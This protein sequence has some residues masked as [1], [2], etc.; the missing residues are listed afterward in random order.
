MVINKNTQTKNSVLL[1]TLL[2]N[3]TLIFLLFLF[4]SQTRHVDGDEGLYLEAARLVAQ[5]KALYFDFFYQQMP[6]LPYL[7]AGWMKV[8]G[9]DFF[10]GRWFSALLTALTGGIFL[11]YVARKT[12]NLLLINLFALLFFSN[13]LI[14]AWAPVVK[15][16][17]LSLLGLTSSCVF[18][19]IWRE[20]QSWWLIAL[21]ALGIGVGV[22]SRLTLGPFILIYLV[23][24]FFKSDGHKWRD[25][26]LFTL[27]VALVSLPS[28]YYFFSDP[29]LFW[30]YNMLYHTHVYPG[31]VD[32]ERRLA[33]AQNLFLGLQIVL[34]FLA[35]QGSILLLI[36]KGWRK[37][38][39][40]DEAFLSLLLL[41][42]IGIHM[43][44][45][46]PYTQYFVTMIPLLLMMSVPAI[47]EIW[48]QPKILSIP[49][50]TVFVILYLGNAKRTMNYE[51]ASMLSDRPEWSLQNIQNTVKILKTTVK[52]GES[53]L[54][55]WPGYAF[56]AGCSSV[57]G[58][59]N[60]MRN[61]GV[62][63]LTQQE[64]TD[65][66]MLSDEDLYGIIKEGKYRVMV[67]GLYH[68][69]SPL[70]KYISHQIEHHYISAGGGVKVQYKDGSELF[71]LVYSEAFEGSIR[72]GK[73]KRTPR[74]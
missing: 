62:Q 65:Y 68:I 6:L 20:K 51:I 34:L 57:P 52:P 69:Q 50:I 1:L 33:T 31:V 19:L 35:A 18:L 71:D 63:K 73:R 70:Y 11:I 67:D 53:C 23:Y 72:N 15:T 46:E 4:L 16:H 40:S 27:I 13:G 39:S 45:A 43:A 8:F 44:S 38:I 55:W 12:K 60:H 54:T 42:F 59:E 48:T 26:I 7:Y 28:F 24:I 22:N 9:F 56:M 32:G 5:G 61:Y 21:A 74:I 58:M 36:K 3:F 14:L 66:K 49:V 10:A 30:Q 29:K 2:F 64:M 41:F 17:P 37:F 47:Q 25:S